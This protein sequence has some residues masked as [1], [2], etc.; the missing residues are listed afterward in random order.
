MSFHHAL[1]V[2]FLKCPELK[3]IEIKKNFEGTVKYSRFPV[4]TNR[5][6]MMSNMEL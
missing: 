2:I 4:I 1:S 5:L 3:C 6:L